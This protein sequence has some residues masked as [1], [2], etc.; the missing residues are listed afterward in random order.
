METKHDKMIQKI[1][2]NCMLFNNTDRHELSTMLVCLDFRVRSCKRNDIINMAGDPFEGVGVVID[3]QVAVVKENVS[4]ERII[5]AILSPGELFGE[6]AAFTGNRIW[7][8]TI[9]AQTDCTVM[10]VPT[11]KLVGQCPRSCTGHRKLIMNMLGILARKA[12][13]LSRQLDYLSIRSIRGRIANYLL[14]QQRQNGTSTFMLS[15][16]RNELADFLNV[17]RPS[18]SREMC[19]MRDE[20]M[21]DFHRSSVRIRD[22]EALKAAAQGQ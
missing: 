18:L 15:M 14:E 10:Y 2:P 22:L 6:M 20:G 17:T 13:T 7:P 19:R 5:L 11:D 3:G 16:N 1:A 12:M 4:G 9:I 8:A 21:L